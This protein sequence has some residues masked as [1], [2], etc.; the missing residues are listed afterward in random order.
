MLSA[1]GKLISTIKRSKD[2]SYFSLNSSWEFLLS[3]LR[4]YLWG[5][6]S[7]LPVLGTALEALEKTIRETNEEMS[8]LH[9]QVKDEMTRVVGEEIKVLAN[10]PAFPFV[11]YDKDGH[12]FNPSSIRHLPDA[13]A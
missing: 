1:L 13:T 6:L 7:K 9:I 3:F 5:E 4:N 11:T 12:L 8:R 10:R 2:G